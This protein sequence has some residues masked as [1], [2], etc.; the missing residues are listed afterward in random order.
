[1]HSKFVDRTTRITLHVDSHMCPLFSF[2]QHNETLRYL[3]D[4][5]GPRLG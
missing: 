1:M 5:V 4:I 2:Q 3:E